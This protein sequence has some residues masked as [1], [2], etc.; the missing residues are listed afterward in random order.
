MA[1]STGQKVF[2]WAMAI[3]MFVGTIG[4]FFIFVLEANNGPV[5]S[6][7]EQAAEDF[8][9]QQQEAA[10]ARLDSSKPLEGYSSD[11][12]DADKVTKLVSKVLDAGSG[13]TIKGNDAISVNYFGWTPDG[14][15]FD[16]SNQN[17]KTEPIELSLEGVIPG[18]TQG[19]KD[20]KVGDTVELTIPS[21]LA[22]G[23]QGSPPNIAPNTPL[24][25]IVEIKEIVKKAE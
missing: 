5:T 8:Q 7:Q 9:K 11:E 2:I 20:K 12:F 18:W 16:S 23:E 1:T 25:F 22:Y 19:L 3:V 10:K 24:K 13:A 21:D 6:P 15:I 17:G 14:V 4:S